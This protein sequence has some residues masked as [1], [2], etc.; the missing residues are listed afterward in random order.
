MKRRALVIAV[1]AAVAAAAYITYRVR[2]AR[3]PL[4]W[5]GTVEARTMDVGSKVGG[6]VAEVQVKEGDLVSPGDPL[7][8][9]EKGDLPAQRLTAEGQLEQAQAAL[10][11]LSLKSV[12]SP[13]RAEIATA[14]ARLRAEEASREKARRD[15]ARL[16]K[17][18]RGG[19]GTRVD[20]ENATLALKNADA[21]VAAAEAQVEDLLRGTPQDI[22]S[23]RG[24]VEVAMGRLQQIDELIGELVIRAPRR[25]RVEALDLRPGDIIAP[26]APA[27]RLLEPDQLYVRIFVPETQLGRVHP[28]LEVPIFV[29]TFP[30]RAFRGR[31]ESVASEGEFTPR[32][33]QTADERADQVF[34]T[35]VGIE[36]GENILRAG[37]AATIQVPR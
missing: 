37:M 10:E 27:A 32:N 28:G 16:Q 13:R 15:E 7:L 22:R 21:T 3:A 25:A 17:L 5:S 33:L 29:D 20:A 19:A 30:G 23:A 24:A 4:T 31:V 6:R 12:S 18:F 35:R 2:H 11:K 34:S 26:N 14:Q 1:V 9:L 8:T 36:Q